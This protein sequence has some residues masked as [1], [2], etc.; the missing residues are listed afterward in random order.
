MH[1]IQQVLGHSSVA[2]TER[3]YAHFSPTHSAKKVLKVLE[4]G[5]SKKAAETR[6]A[7]ETKRKHGRGL[8]LPVA[9]AK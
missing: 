9:K 6:S 8:L 1:D 3:Y 7:L 5:H 2:T 4:G